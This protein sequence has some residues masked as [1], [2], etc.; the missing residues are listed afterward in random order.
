MCYNTDHSAR[1]LSP[2]NLNIYIVIHIQA[3][4]FRKMSWKE[5]KKRRGR[6]Q[7][8]KIRRKGKEWEQHYA[9]LT[10]ETNIDTFRMCG[11]ACLQLHALQKFFSYF[12]Q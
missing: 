9:L 11:V 8:K 12:K 4:G 2:H 10:F 5:R 3:Q 1:R 6:N 7:E